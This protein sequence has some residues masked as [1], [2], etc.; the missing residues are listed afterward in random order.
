MAE[1]ALTLRLDADTHSRL[2]R[3]AFEQDTTITALVRE[4]IA[5][6]IRGWGRDDSGP[7]P[8][9]RQARRNMAPAP[10][11]EPKEKRADTR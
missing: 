8:V 9:S 3:E 4:A 1:K 2:R 7:W 6:H 10:A 5:E 11:E